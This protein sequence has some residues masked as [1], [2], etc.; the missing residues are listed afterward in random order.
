MLHKD[1][2][3]LDLEKRAD[4]VRS[5]ILPHI[6]RE[7]IANS[8]DASATDIR[9]FC[10]QCNIKTVRGQRMRVYQVY[11]NDDGSGC[12]DPE[13]L[14][15]VGSSTSDVSS[16]KR[17]R[18]GH[19]LIDFVSCCS[20]AEITT[21]TNRL[22]FTKDG[23]SVVKRS[24]KLK[25][26]HVSG[27]L[28]HRGEGEDGL[29]NY[30]NSIILPGDVI[31]FSFN[32]RAIGVRKPIKTIKNI[33][34]QTV[35]FDD[36]AKIE[37]KCYRDTDIEIFSR[38][39]EIPYIYEMGIPVD[40][41][42]WELPFDINVLQK[43]PLDVNRDVLPDRYKQNLISKLVQ[44]L[45]AEY[46]NFMSEQNQVPIELKDNAINASQLGKDSSSKMVEICTGFK[47]ETIVR[48]NPFDKADRSESHELESIGFNPI[49]LNHMPAGVKALLDSTP[50][51]A[52]VHDNKCKIHLSSANDF[53][54]ITERESKC[55]AFYSCL[56][57]ALLRKKV[58]CKRH[59][60]GATAVWL[61]GVISF[62]IDSDW[63]WDNPISEQS[64]STVLHEC[65]HD[66]HSGHGIDF[67]KEV[68]TLGARFGLW[69]S[70]N[71]SYFDKLGE[72]LLEKLVT[73]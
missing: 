59:Q 72:M 65:A 19:G 51:V 32:G 1:W 49:H 60:G 57:S 29:E 39:G 53:P 9:L 67:C 68:E 42:P 13:I 14:R 64:I 3:G 21:L 69:V 16:S 34:L 35:I 47:P 66:K 62:D 24:N 31:H 11:C 43:T 70:S 10:Q 7:L 33:R 61:D 44:H 12:S 37:S 52:L 30:I 26:M 20:N 4:K 36:D 55:L 46:L 27:F 22:S 38:Y 58:L 48:R 40:I 71:K 28:Y 25:G 45:D 23:C 6:L 73:A 5:R 50:T 15:T 17:G 63:L 56:A 8:L 41:A 2:F 54:N 18:F